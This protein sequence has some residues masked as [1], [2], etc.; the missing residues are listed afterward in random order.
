MSPS[1]D[2]CPRCRDTGWVYPSADR[3]GVVRCECLKERIRASKIAAIP[4]QFTN[5]TFGNYLPVDQSQANA[6]NAV[7]GEPGRSFF[8]YGT[9][10]RGKTHLAVAQYRTL[11]EAGGN[12]LFVSMSSLLA[13]LRAAEVH[14]QTSAVIQRVRHS[15]EFHLFIDDVD[16]FKP[17]EFKSEVLFDLFD[18]LYKRKLS[19]TITSNLGLEALSGVGR[20]DGAILRRIDD[21]C[22]PVEV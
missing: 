16:K 1:S 5:A 8:L 10:R 17:T 7:S 12:A 15:D 14:D 9:Y 2:K 4:A 11:I 13:E 19:L 6:L 21:V 18:T 22:L 3:A 20:L